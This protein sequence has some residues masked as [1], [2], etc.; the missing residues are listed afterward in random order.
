MM[1]KPL[2]LFQTTRRSNP[3]S[4]GE[5]DGGSREGLWC[6]RR[7]VTNFLLCICLHGAADVLSAAC[8]SIVLQFLFLPT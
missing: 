8:V 2:S 7:L 5:A 4:H 6:L 1:E 3:C